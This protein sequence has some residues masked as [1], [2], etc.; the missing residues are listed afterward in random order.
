MSIA[1]LKD[2]GLFILALLLFPW[3]VVQAE[4]GKGT[5]QD[6]V[7][8]EYVD[9]VYKDWQEGILLDPQ[10]NNYIVTYKDGYGFY[11]SVMFEA[12][13][14]I[15]PVL[16]SKFKHPNSA[17]TV[18]YEYKLKNGTR[19]KQNINMFLA[20]VSSINPGSP[21][22]PK[23][24]DG[25]AIP[26]L[27]D[28]TLRLSWMYDSEEHLGGLAPGRS[29]GEFKVESSD[30]P[31]IT[32]MEITGAAKATTWL[33]H[34]PPF[35]TPVGKQL[36]EL[37]TNNFVP[38]PAAV[39]LIPVPNPFDAAAVL[40]N[41]QRHVNQDLVGMKLIDPAFASQLDRLFQTAI[42][43]A[44]GGNTVALKGNLK[45]LRQMLKREHADVDKDD[46]DWDKDD[47]KNK[48]KDKSRLIDK[49]AVK[50]L[51]FDLKYIQKRLG[52]ND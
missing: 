12:A 10:T 32:V 21:M 4:M 9:G 47:D 15:E 18:V 20:H 22:G 24:W 23:G 49:L 2:I 5:V 38:R 11:N 7:T 40:T 44:K 29:I 37:K 36:W 19:S 42:A 46:E 3:P 39:P 31:G 26:T 6:P 48:E 41:M 8:R 43:A 33:G 34:T 45:D 30:L 52:N 1:S 51:D 13:T 27:T 14:K 35:D 25:R 28:S 50:V 17:N 16:K